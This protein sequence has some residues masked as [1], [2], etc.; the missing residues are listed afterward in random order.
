VS[1]SAPPSSLLAALPGVEERRRVIAHLRH[2][3][4][5]CLTA[6]IGYSEDLL[7]TIEEGPEEILRDLRALRQAGAEVLGRI[8]ETLG[9]EAIRNVTAEAL[10]ALVQKLGEAC[11]EPASAIAPLCA[12]LVAAAER[13]GLYGI[14]PTLCRIQASGVMLGDLLEGYVH[15]ASP[16][17]LR[18]RMAPD[19]GAAQAEGAAL[20]RAYQR[21]RLL[22]VDDNSVSRDVLHQWLVRQGYEVDEASGGERALELM[23]AHDYDLILLD[24]VMPD[25]T[26]I[27]VLD[28][29]QAE[30]RLGRAPV[31]M[32]SALDEFDGVV[33]AIERGADDFVSKP[34][35]TVL[36][37]ARIRNYLEL[38]RHRDREQA[39]QATLREIRVA[40]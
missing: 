7:E 2:E 13:E 32:I 31:I 9:V 22:L 36:L 11:K 34:F 30:G 40:R 14:I 24:I 23:R 10:P 21:G 1:E 15:E 17:L 27:E 8:N 28:V 29:L 35:N 12:G 18:A 19:L 3:L 39:Y 20:E 37:G 6:V 25:K 16:S 5:T 26:G 4:R 33:R 38:K